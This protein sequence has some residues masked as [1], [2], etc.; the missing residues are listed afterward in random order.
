M[1]QVIIFTKLDKKCIVWRGSD[2]NNLPT[3]AKNEKK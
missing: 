1:Y 3:F 2:K